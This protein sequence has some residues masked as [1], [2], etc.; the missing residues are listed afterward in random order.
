MDRKKIMDG[1]LPT[2]AYGSYFRLVEIEDAEFIVSLR[3]DEKLSR[4]INATSAQ[5]EDQINWLKEYKIRE[6]RGR[7][8]YIICLKE[9]R[10][11]KLGLNRIY[12]ITADYFEFGSWVYSPEADSNTSILGD[13]FVKSLAFEKLHLKICNLQ[14]RKKNRRVLWYTKSFNP[15]MV[16]EDELSYY[17]ELNHDNFSMQRAKLLKLLNIG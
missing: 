4:H 5:I 7:D 14:V 15:I 11:T 1:I 12:D 17:F 13:L 9:D 3:N 6:E 2:N 10:T 8:F 16:G